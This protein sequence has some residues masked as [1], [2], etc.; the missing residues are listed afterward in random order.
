MKRG[1]EATAPALV[2]GLWTLL[3]MLAVLEHY[4]LDELCQLA[5]EAGLADLAGNRLRKV[6]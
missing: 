1:V 5:K 3:S 4:N 6:V 2:A